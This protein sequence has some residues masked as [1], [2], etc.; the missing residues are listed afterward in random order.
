MPFKERFYEKIVKHS[1]IFGPNFPEILNKQKTIEN[2]INTLGENT[3]V[4]LSSLIGDE[5]G[6][7]SRKTI[8]NKEL[9]TIMDAFTKS[10][11]KYGITVSYGFSDKEDELYIQVDKCIFTQ[12]GVEKRFCNYSKKFLEA[13]FN[14]T[15]EQEMSLEKKDY[16]CSFKLKL[17]K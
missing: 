15:A 4:S 5:F 7:D 8:T 10:M 17:K 3:I 16:A 1:K 9:K 2:A 11:N 14:A 12:G 13:Y 6:K